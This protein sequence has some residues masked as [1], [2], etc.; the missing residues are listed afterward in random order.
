MEIESWFSKFALDSSS[1]LLLGRGPGALQTG[2][3]GGFLRAFDTATRYVTY[4]IITELS[5]LIAWMPGNRRAR[6]VVHDFVDSEISL[7]IACF[8]ARL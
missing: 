1:E 6:K 8:P 7:A 5:T 3:G 4:S 2:E